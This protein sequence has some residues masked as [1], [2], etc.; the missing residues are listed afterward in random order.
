MYETLIRPYE[1]QQPNKSEMIGIDDV[2]ERLKRAEVKKE[3]RRLRQIERSKAEKEKNTLKRKRDEDG[4]PGAD[5]DVE[6]KRIKDGAEHDGDGADDEDLQGE[7]VAST[8]AIPGFPVDVV[9][10]PT[11]ADAALPPQ[12]IQPR[13]RS[14][15]PSSPPPTPISMV[16]AKPIAEVRGHT[17]YLTFARLLPPAEEKS[18]SSDIEVLLNAT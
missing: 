16:L 17:S 10:A 15:S 4:E 8:S 9:G 14:A 2:K 13:T 11:S 1:L 3:E 18:N 5:A 12:D 7:N 6:R